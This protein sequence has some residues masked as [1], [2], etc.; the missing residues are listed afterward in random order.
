MP[1]SVLNSASNLSGKTLLTEENDESKS[2]LLTFER[3]PL[4]PFAVES[5]SAVVPNL[6]VDKVDG[7]DISGGSWT[8]N[9]GGATSES[10]QVY[11]NRGGRY[12]KVG[13][14]VTC[15][16]H[17]ALSTLG[18][19]T[20]A[21]QI[22]GLPFT[23]GAFNTARG[24]VTFGYWTAL[25][26]SWVWIGGYVPSSGTVAPIVGRQSAGTGITALTQADLSALTDVIFMISYEAAS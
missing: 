26:S 20:G 13:R 12:F 5:G 14:Q 1:T 16:G 7:F 24:V 17:M 2:G 3:A 23:S 4:A 11:S 18:T 6:D 10:G 19:I 15:W 25:T 21:V 22:E 9:W 8:P